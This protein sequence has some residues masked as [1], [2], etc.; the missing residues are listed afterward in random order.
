[1]LALLL[2]FLEIQDEIKPG[3]SE[4]FVWVLFTHIGAFLQKLCKAQDIH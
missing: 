3:A 4:G 1:M 2:Q